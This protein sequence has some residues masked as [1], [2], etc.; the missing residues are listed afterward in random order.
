MPRNENVIEQVEP[1]DLESVV[2]NNLRRSQRNIIAPAKFK[3]YVTYFLQPEKEVFI[4]DNV[5]FVAHEEYKEPE[6]FQ[7]ATSCKD[8]AQWIE[9]MNK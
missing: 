4:E 7:E 2:T 6:T 9:A 5:T 3:D 1:M 8:S